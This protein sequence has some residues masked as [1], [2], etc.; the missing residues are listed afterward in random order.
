MKKYLGILLFTIILLTGCKGEKPAIVEIPDVSD[1]KEISLKDTRLELNS[2]TFL[3]SATVDTPYTVYIGKDSLNSYFEVNYVLTSDIGVDRFLE[4]K[5]EEGD[6]ITGKIGNKFYAMLI[7]EE[8]TVVMK[9]DI[10][11]YN[12][13]PVVE[14]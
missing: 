8:Y 1:V 3:S 5:K 11:F 4:D 2:K 14:K 13:L 10:N 7:Y 6:Y 9:S 12:Y